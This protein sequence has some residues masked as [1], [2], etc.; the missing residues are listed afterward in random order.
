MLTRCDGC[1]TKFGAEGL[2]TVAPLGAEV[3]A[4]GADSLARAGGGTAVAGGAV[5]TGGAVTAGGAV[6]TGGSGAG[7][8]A[9]VDGGGV[10]LGVDAGSCGRAAAISG[11]AG[12]A[13]NACVIH[14]TAPHKPMATT[15]A[16][17]RYRATR[18]SRLNGD[19]GLKRP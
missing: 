19:V 11:A 16:S 5:G 3:D 1:T 14:I 4:M 17:A 13:K 6:V 7:L 15:T 12:G 18:F 9:V 8:A 2:S 10:G